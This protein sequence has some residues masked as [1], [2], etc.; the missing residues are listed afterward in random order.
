[1]TNLGEKGSQQKILS[2]AQPY[3]LRGGKGKKTFGV[4]SVRGG[5]VSHSAHQEKLTAKSVMTTSDPRGQRT[6]IKE[7]SLFSIQ[8]AK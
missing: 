2:D 4:S 5:E 6:E 3:T 7:K 1:M 8:G